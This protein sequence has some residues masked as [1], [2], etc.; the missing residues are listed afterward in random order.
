MSAVCVWCALCHCTSFRPA[1][2]M[3][4]T[5]AISVSNS[6]SLQARPLLDAGKK[7]DK[8]TMSESR[9]LQ[10]MSDTSSL[11]ASLQQQGPSQQLAYESRYLP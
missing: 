6:A 9:W 8:R 3:R 1:L 11:F 5:E 2:A 7:V 10:I 4:C